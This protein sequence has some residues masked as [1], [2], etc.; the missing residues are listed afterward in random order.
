MKRV[1]LCT[2]IISCLS[3]I[4]ASTAGAALTTD[5]TYAAANQA[6]QDTVAANP[7]DDPSFPGITGYTIYQCNVVSRRQAF[8]DVTEQWTDG[9]FCDDV[10]QE[11]ALRTDI[12]V[13]S[14]YQSS[15]TDQPCYASAKIARDKFGP[16]RLRHAHH[17]LVVKTRNGWRGKRAR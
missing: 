10:L 11:V 17:Y 8:C 9:L 3:A 5:S 1:A 12:A 16:P 13:T 14:P 2:A 6:E 15:T 7:P 4:G